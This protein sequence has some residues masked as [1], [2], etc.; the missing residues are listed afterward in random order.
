MRS[1]EFDKANKLSDEYSAQYFRN[2]AHDDASWV[3]T[4]NKR[5]RM[6]AALVSILRREKSEI[7]DIG[8]IGCGVGMFSLALCKAFRNKIFITSGD[9]SAY[10]VAVTRSKLKE[11]PNAVVRELN[12]ESIDLATESLDVLVSLDVVEHLHHP[13][14]FFEE[15]YRVL[16]PEGLLLFS[17]P[18]PES[19]GSRV[20]NPSS[21]S[22]DDR[23]LWFARRD[24]SHV[25]IRNINSWRDVCRRVGFTKCTDGTDY[26]WDI[27]YFR[28]IPS[29]FQKVFFLGFRF[30]LERLI[31]FFPWRLGENYY[32]VWRK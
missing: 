23:F 20:K 32:G 22:E 18:N 7:R 8:D 13:E 28:G 4:F 14:L 1:P 3:V 15:A 21:F 16:R 17:T 11:W 19:L 12:A 31:P 29:A 6:Y 25:N 24:C 9:M 27:P 30:V 10:A 5:R 2:Y 26:L